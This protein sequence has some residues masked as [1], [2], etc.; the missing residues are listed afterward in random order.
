M[1]ICEVKGKSDLFIVL[2]GSCYVSVHLKI[3]IKQDL[4]KA[5]DHQREKEHEH[6]NGECQRFIKAKFLLP[7]M[8][9]I[10]GDTVKKYLAY[11]YS[12]LL[13]EDTS[14]HT[15][16]L[17]ATMKKLGTRASFK[18]DDGGNNSALSALKNKLNWK[19]Y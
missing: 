2:K 18:E 14:A 9:V 11:D 13:K 1:P 10:N 5:N 15:Q 3:T 7:E 12:T 4:L 17:V 6:K 8:S 19:N 16:N